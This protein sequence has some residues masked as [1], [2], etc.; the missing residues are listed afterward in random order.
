VEVQTFFQKYGQRTAPAA[1]ADALNVARGTRVYVLERVRGFDKRRIGHFLSWFH[2]RLNLR[3]TE[4]FTQPLY[5]VIEAVSHV[6]PERSR[7]CIAAVAAGPA[8][9]K[10]L[11]VDRNTPLLQRKR[12][13]TDAGDRMLEYAVNH[14]RTDDFTYTLDIR[15]EWK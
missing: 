7:E 8:L 3:G 4:D 5:S 12:W 9:A 6:Y 2:P 13:V 15:R 10:L 1:V 11:E 14:Y